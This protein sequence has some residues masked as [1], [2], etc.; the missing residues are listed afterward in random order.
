M[1]KRK[2]FNIERKIFLAGLLVLFFMNFVSCANIGVSPASISFKD[3]LRGGYSERMVVVSADSDEPITV[4]LKP[5][6]EI[7]DW[8]NFSSG[9]FTVSKGKPYLL[10]VSVLPPSDIPNGE[11]NGFLRL[12]VGGSVESIEEHAVGTIKSSLDLAISVGITD[13]EIT[14]CVASD[15]EILSAEQ[16]DDVILKMKVANEG[17]IR[18]KPNVELDIWD[19]DKIS[20]INTED[21]LGDE[22][23]PSTE[24]ELEFRFNS[25]D[26]DIGQYW[27]DAYVI[28]CSYSQ[29]LT[30][31]VMEPGAL[32]A[33][34][35]LLNILTKG[36]V[37][38]GET[39]SII[40]NFK[41]T[42]EKEIDAQFRGEVTK[43]GKIIDILE[44]DVFKVPVSSV[45]EFKF[46]FT[47]NS[48]GKYIVSGRVYYAGK[49]T[50]EQSSSLEAVSSRSGFS[51][52]WLIYAGFVFAIGL[53][54][55]K[56]RK[57]KKIY[58][59]KLRGIR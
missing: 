29:A 17:N 48:E 7:A 56:I 32:S 40:A 15:L 5:R 36:T 41:N 31:D 3:V 47:P 18:L 20:V 33:K 44:S 10:K 8:L 30:F 19:S 37:G 25:E 22:I 54:F 53:L 6:G 42:G 9:E 23:L 59:D 45:E 11:Y 27:S 50:F 57:E 34:G 14:R 4:T 43:N 1:K 13:V 49:K 35:V 16:G 26:F 24:K 46:Y 39:S 21:F 28:D 52:V 58:L 55:Y 12:E 38:V 2:E 51:F